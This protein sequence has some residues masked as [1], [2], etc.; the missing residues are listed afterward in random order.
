MAKVK[1]HR[2]DPKEKYRIINEFFEIISNLKSKKEIVDFFVGL[3]T[4]SEVVMMARRIQVAKMI[5]EGKGYDEIMRRLKV[6]CQTVTKIEH[7]LHGKGEEYDIWISR[8]LNELNRRE[9]YND[10]N[11]SAGSK[12]QRSQLDKYPGHRLLKELFM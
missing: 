8:C 6:S 7:W 12:Y 4:P 3:L 5:V 10:K 2:I 11:K 9:K 1:S